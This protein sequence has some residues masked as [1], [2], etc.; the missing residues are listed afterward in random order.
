MISGSISGKRLEINL[1]KDTFQTFL[2]DCDETLG[3]M[4]GSCKKV[5]DMRG[6]PINTIH[7]L[8]MHD[9]Y[10]VSEVSN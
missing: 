5:Y 10:Y 2:A 8:V 4:N 1:S 3:L 9:V 7:E 6:N